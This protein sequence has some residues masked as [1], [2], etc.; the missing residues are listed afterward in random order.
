LGK[1]YSLAKHQ[2][3]AHVIGSNFYAAPD[4][5]YVAAGKSCHVGIELIER[6]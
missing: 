4:A 5:V 1:Y 3:G 2:R 6:R